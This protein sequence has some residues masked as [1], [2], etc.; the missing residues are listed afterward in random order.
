M[1]L[2][3]EEKLHAQLHRARVAHAGH[4]TKGSSARSGIVKAQ[5][6][7]VRMVKD[8]E[9][10]PPELKRFRFTEVNVLGQSRIEARR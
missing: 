2:M 6:G 9:D 3:L 4:E 10:F 8:V 1:K 7:E 5:G